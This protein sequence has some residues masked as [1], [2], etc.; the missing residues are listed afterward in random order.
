MR[1]LFKFLLYKRKINVEIYGILMISQIQ[2]IIVS[3]GNTVCVIYQYDNQHFFANSPLCNCR[4]SG[5]EYKGT[6]IWQWQVDCLE[7]G[8]HISSPSYY[9]VL[10]KVDLD[11][12]DL[13]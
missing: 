8:G 5:M 10:H 7:V 12:Y 4:G 11:M 2:K 3:A 13:T 9:I 1:K 6:N